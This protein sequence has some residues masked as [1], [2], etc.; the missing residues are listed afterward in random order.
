MA[1][2]SPLGYA[3]LLDLDD[4]ALSSLEWQ[5]PGGEDGSDMRRR[6]LSASL[7]EADYVT[8]HDEKRY[9]APLLEGGTMARTRVVESGSL[10]GMIWFG[11]W[12]FTIAFA[13]LAWWQSLVGLVIWP[14]YLGLLARAG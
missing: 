5:T 14:Y 11:G 10:A 4:K 1:F 12:L 8:H 13:Q 2:L 7:R 9:N 3:H 6:E